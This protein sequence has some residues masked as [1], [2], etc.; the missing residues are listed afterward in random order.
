MN[1][2][3]ARTQKQITDN[4]LVRGLVFVVEQN[5]D[6]EIE[7]DGLDDVC[8]LFVAYMDDEAVGAA[9]LFHNKVGRVSTLKPYRNQGV[10]S[11]LMEKIESY[12]LKQGMDTLILHAQLYV[13]E[14][15][16]KRGYI[17]KGDIFQEAEIN[18]IKMIKYLV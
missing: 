9:R 13:K 1:V 8:T 4:F 12:A 18:H 14:F 10:A 5:I 6:Y 3:V 15:Y 11:A 2:V 16:L 17:A 7:F